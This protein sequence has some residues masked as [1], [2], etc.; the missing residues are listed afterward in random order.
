[1]LSINEALLT[2][3]VST[4]ISII[5]NAIFDIGFTVFK[6]TS[7]ISNCPKIVRQEDLRSV[8]DQNEILIRFKKLIT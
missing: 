3:R 8:L 1:M 4:I 5:V 7:A 2:E 6:F